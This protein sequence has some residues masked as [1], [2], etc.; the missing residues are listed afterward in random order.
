MPFIRKVISAALFVMISAI[1]FSQKKSPSLRIGINP[2]SLAESQL[3]IGPCISYRV[4]DRFQLW[5]EASYI[6]ANSYMPAEWKKMKGF[7]FIFQPRYFTGHQRSFF[8][9]PEFRIKA[10]QFNNRLNVINQFTQDT[11]YKYHLRERQQLIGG[12]LVFGKIFTLSKKKG[13]QLEVTMGFGEKRRLI[14]YFQLPEG[15]A[16]QDMRGSDI[17]I[18]PGYE[19][20]N[21][22]VVYFPMAGRILWEIK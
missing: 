19:S 6:F 12:A 18:S 1:S 11:L 8:I 17:A 16:V 3:S 15:Y 13:I 5:T 21:D 20:H 14:K 2:L 10:F 9:A 7:R 4:S 22:H